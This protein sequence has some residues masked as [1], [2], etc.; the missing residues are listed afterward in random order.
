MYV[1]QQK[2]FDRM[3][4]ILSLGHWIEVDKD[5]KNSLV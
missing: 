2:V 4:L 1:I 3:C 5:K